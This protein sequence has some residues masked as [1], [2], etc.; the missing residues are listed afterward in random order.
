MLDDFRKAL[1]QFARR[2][3]RQGVHVGNDQ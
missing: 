2:Q 1:P 3:G